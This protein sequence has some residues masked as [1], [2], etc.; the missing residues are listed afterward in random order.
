MRI[1]TI[2]KGRFDDD[3]VSSMSRKP[4]EFERMLIGRLR[5][6]FEDAERSDYSSFERMMIHHLRQMR[7]VLICN[8]VLPI[9]ILNS[10]FLD[11]DLVSQGLLC[12]RDNE[13]TSPK[14]PRDKFDGRGAYLKTLAA[15][16]Q[17]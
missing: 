12:H 2:I 7:T 9:K 10:R 11:D 15:S 3:S 16:F 13:V 8:A 17:R 5:E 4:W 14:H 1:K 6:R